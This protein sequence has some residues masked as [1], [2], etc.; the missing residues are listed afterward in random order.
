MDTMALRASG[1]QMGC[2]PSRTQSGKVAWY[3]SLWHNAPQ[4]IVQASTYRVTDVLPSLSYMLCLCRGGRLEPFN[5]LLELSAQLYLPYHWTGSKS[6]QHP[7]HKEHHG[8]QH[9]ATWNSLLSSAHTW[10]LLFIYFGIVT[11]ML[12]MSNW[13]DNQ[14]ITQVKGWPCA[15]LPLVRSMPEWCTSV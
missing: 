6:G 14:V 13:N 2:W 1:W 11:V 12:L 10:R 8:G 4:P 15:Q 9:Y 7:I 3:A 5:V